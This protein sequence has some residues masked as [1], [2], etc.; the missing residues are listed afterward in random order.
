MA[1]SPLVALSAESLKQNNSSARKYIFHRAR[2]DILRRSF[3]NKRKRASRPSAVRVNFE[4]KQFN[5][6]WDQPS[7]VESWRQRNTRS[8]SWPKYS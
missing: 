1:I 6:I 2:C 8:N 7:G 5:S 4:H 3:C